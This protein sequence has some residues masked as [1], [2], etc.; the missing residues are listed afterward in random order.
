MERKDTIYSC[1]DSEE[2]PMQQMQDKEKESCMSK[3]RKVDTS[4]ALDASLVITERSRTDV[5]K[6]DTSSRSGMIQTLMIQI[7]NSYMTK[8]QWLRIL[9]SSISEVPIQR[10]QTI[11]YGV[12]K[13]LNTA[14]SVSGLNTAYSNY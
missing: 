14:Y 13:L 4:K 12:F 8:S 11:E 2:Q 7:S 10:I 3:E 5:E 1:S 9:Q 6:Q